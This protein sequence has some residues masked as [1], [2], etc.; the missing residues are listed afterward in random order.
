MRLLAEEKIQL[1][2]RRPVVVVDVP[3]RGHQIGERVRH[4]R[5]EQVVPGIAY[6]E[7]NL[8]VG[9][10]TVWSIGHGDDLPQKYAEGEHVGLRRESILDER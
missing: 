6:V 3:A 2:E 1:V 10:Q 8:L 4:W 5:N 7:Q 9:E